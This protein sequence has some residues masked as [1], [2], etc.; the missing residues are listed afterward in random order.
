MPYQGNPRGQRRGPVEAIAFRVVETPLGDA[1]LRSEGRTLH[2]AGKLKLDNWRGA[3][4]VQF[5]IEDGAWA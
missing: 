1:L 3:K 2:L 5:Q 4:G